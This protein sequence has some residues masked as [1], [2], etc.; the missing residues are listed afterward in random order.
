MTWCGRLFDYTWNI[1][2]GYM[3]RS[4]SWLWRRRYKHTPNYHVI[5]VTGITSKCRPSS[6]KQKGAGVGVGEEQT[7]P[8]QKECYKTGSLTRPLP[9]HRP[10]KLKHKETRNKHATKKNNTKKAKK[11]KKNKNKTKQWN[12]IKS[13][14]RSTWLRASCLRNQRS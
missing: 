10:L 3:P 4:L 11:Q 13:H 2:T 8:I 5:T 6:W 9:S 1:H 12:P 14:C 7:D